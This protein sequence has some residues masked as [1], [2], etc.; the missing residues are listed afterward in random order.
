MRP[1]QAEGL[2]HKNNSTPR[3][4]SFRRLRFQ[5]RVQRQ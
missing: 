2:P 3:Q 5:E 4:A 1:P